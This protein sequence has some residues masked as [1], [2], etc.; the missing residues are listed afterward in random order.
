MYVSG[1]N[2][3]PDAMELYGLDD[4]HKY[5][6]PPLPE[7][8]PVGAALTALADRELDR[9]PRFGD[10]ERRFVQGNDPRLRQVLG[11]LSPGELEATLGRHYGQPGLGARIEAATDRILRAMM[12]DVA[13]PRLSALAGRT[14]DA[15]TME[16]IAARFSAFSRHAVGPGALPELADEVRAKAGLGWPGP[17][18]GAATSARLIA[19]APLPLHY[20]GQVGLEAGRGLGRMAV[21]AALEGPGGALKDGASF[22][23]EDAALPCVVGERAAE[24]LRNLKLA[25]ESGWAGARAKSGNSKPLFELGLKELAHH[26]IDHAVGHAKAALLAA[27]PATIDHLAALR[28]TAALRLEPI[29]RTWSDICKSNAR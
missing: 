17:A 16:R 21:G 11:Q 7:R 20:A 13:L 22:L 2:D 27:D 15:A 10:A 18:R 4:N 23:L 8:A 5:R 26:A 1:R 25:F 29:E 14:S 9:Y 6:L 28:P 12:A 19:D 24:Q 3:G